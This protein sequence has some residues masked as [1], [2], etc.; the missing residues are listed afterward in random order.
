MHVGKNYE[1]YPAF[2]P[3]SARSTYPDWAPKSFT[4]STATWAGTASGSVPAT[5]L[6][7]D[8]VGPIAGPRARYACP[9]FDFGGGV[10][11]TLQ[12]D[13]YLV[14]HLQLKMRIGGDWGVNGVLPDAATYN[15]FAQW[16]SFSSFIGST[17]TPPELYLQPTRLVW[18]ATPWPP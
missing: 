1:L 16:T 17:S 13:F 7:L 8:A 6:V 4:I 5:P 12:V 11:A 18:A 9:L 10:E 14:D 2:R 15:F 3:W